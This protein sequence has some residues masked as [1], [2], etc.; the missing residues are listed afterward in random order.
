MKKNNLNHAIFFKSKLLQLLLIVFVL[1]PGMAVQSQETTN[2]TNAVYPT[3]GVG[4]GFFYPGDVNDYIEYSLPSSYIIEYGTPEI[5]MLIDLHAGVT[6]R[7]KRFDVSAMLEYDIAPKFIMVEGG[8]DITFVFSRVAPGI[9]ANYY[10]PVGTGR[11]AFFLGGNVNYSFM[12]FEDFRA[13]SPG[14][15]IQ[16]GFSM[17]FG[18]FNLQPFGAFNYASGTDSDNSSWGKDFKLNFT[19]GQ[20]GVYLSFHPA[21][22]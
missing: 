5:F 11:H 7:M 12:I 16:L 8:D 19:N 15:K 18:K 2:K 3:F 4:F 17:Q 20:V 13:S 21:I 22:N 1:M 6:F 14:F 9:T 10:V